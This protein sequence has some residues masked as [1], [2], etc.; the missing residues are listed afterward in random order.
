MWA[1]VLAPSHVANVPSTTLFDWP[2]EPVNSLNVEKD[3]RNSCKTTN[4][5]QLQQL[6]GNNG[7]LH[8]LLYNQNKSQCEEMAVWLLNA[9]DA[10]RKTQPYNISKWVADSA[11][12]ETTKEFVLSYGTSEPQA[13]WFARASLSGWRRAIRI[14]ST[15][16][17][18]D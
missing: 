17:A 15:R 1:R 16:D 9:P 4:W 2:A 13:W 18:M 10:W 7:T 6:D 8:A 12:W 5:S 11:W 14:A 3:Q